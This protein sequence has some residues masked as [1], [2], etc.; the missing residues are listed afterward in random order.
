[1]IH[2]IFAIDQYGGMGYNGTLP[3]PHCPADLA[4]FKYLTTGHVVVMGRKSWDD[5]KLP[6]PLVGRTVYVATNRPVYHASAISGDITEQL[7]ML[8][9][10]HPDQIIWLAGGPAL[11]EQCKD[12]IDRV[13]LTHFAKSYKV[14]TKLDK[15]FLSGWQ[16][17]RASAEPN[18]NFT[19]VEYAPL[20]ARTQSNPDN[21]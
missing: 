18:T 20:F 13:Y 2:A 19:F 6:K 10:R 14:D 15:T 11:L 7:L 5:P 21:R 8:E 4:N 17:V 3:W 16:A 1:M 9:R 12:V